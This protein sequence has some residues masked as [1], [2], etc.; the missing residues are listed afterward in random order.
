MPTRRETYQQG[1]K[2]TI[3]RSYYLC[4]MGGFAF[5]L[6]GLGENGET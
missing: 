3:G 1:G 2:R 4:K 6:L 5:G